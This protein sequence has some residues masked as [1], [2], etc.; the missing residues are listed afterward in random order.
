MST[1]ARYDVHSRPYR[2]DRGTAL[3]LALGLLAVFAMLAV[4][5]VDYMVI[6]NKDTALRLTELRAEQAAEGGVRAA[7][8][9]VQAAVTSGTADAIVSA[10]IDLEFPVYIKELP[11]QNSLVASD[12]LHI[13]THVVVSEESAK[14]NLNFAPPKVLCK[15]LGVSLDQARQIRSV[16]P[17]IDGSAAD[18]SDINRRWLSN[19]DELV[20]RG[21]MKPSAYAA[22][23]EELLTVYSVADPLNAT[24]YVNVNTAPA[25]VLEAI[26]DITPETATAV[27]NARPFSSIDALVAATGKGP[28]AFNLRAE[29]A[30][31]GTLPQELSFTPRAWRIVSESEVQRTFADRPSQILGSARVEAVIALDAQGV[32]H[33]T[34]WNQGRS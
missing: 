29:A 10:P 27:A 12:T 8:A 15:V 17:R 28:E 24:G 32:S 5:W 31:P 6:Q 20:T 9:A 14:I 3:V 21:L 11:A 30:A 13:K 23:N 7:T 34:Y 19:P 1:N 4:A 26:L 25:P 22:V 2:S 33:V 16:L 18:P